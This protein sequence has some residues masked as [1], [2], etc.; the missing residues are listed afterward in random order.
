MFFNTHL[1][2]LLI[3]GG[4]H[5][6]NYQLLDT[7]LED[8]IEDLDIDYSDIEIVSG[9][10]EGADML[11]EKFA[12]NHNSINLKVF[13][14]NWR[15]YGKSAG[16][17]RNKEMI[18]YISNFQNK[19]VIAFVSPNS[20]GTRNTIELA[21]KKGIR[22]LE[23]P[24]TIEESY[25][26]LFEG[27]YRDSK[28]E[29]NFILDWEQNNKED[30]IKLDIL[31]CIHKTKY[32]KNL[33]YYGYKIN[34][35]SAPQDR[36]DFLFDI[37]NNTNKYVEII[38]KC[39]ED[40]YEKSEIKFFNYILKLPSRSSINSLICDRIKSNFDN[41][42]EII[43]TKKPSLDLDINWEKFKDS[44]KK[45]YY[46]NIEKYLNQLIVRL[47]KEEVFSISKIP[48][49]Y[50]RYLK[51]MINIDGVKIENSENY[52]LLIIDD[53]FTT[54]STIN[55]VLNALEDLKFKGNITILTLIDN[56]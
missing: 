51:P 5:F 31:N 40:F 25:S 19:L 30:I 36:K 50:R 32:H 3:C 1:Y 16:P 46:D 13:P 14:A 12:Q 38:D 7:V 6:N 11:G 47:R 35:I 9:H 48:P 21:K 23:V 17:I 44:F 8:L 24:Y 26:E 52:N 49:M 45:D 54:G 10:C 56:T 4:R 43:L 33:R 55:M 41:C 39:I 53:T 2:R 18:N 27:I 34:K 42:E 28:D 22:V 15:L 37:K 20:K 29:N